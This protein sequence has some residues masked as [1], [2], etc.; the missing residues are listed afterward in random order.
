MPDHH[1]TDALRDSVLAH[2]T[3]YGPQ[4]DAAY[5]WR[6]PALP[7]GIHFETGSDSLAQA[8]VRLRRILNKAWHEG[9]VSRHDIARWYV[10]RWGG[11]KRNLPETLNDY[12]TAPEGELETR[13]TKGI[14]SWSKVLVVR[15]PDLYAI[16]DARVATSLNALQLIAGH[17]QPI[18]F[19][20]LRNQNDTIDEFQKW[21]RARRYGRP[22]YLPK[23][24]VYPTYLRVLRE[25]AGGVG[26]ASLDEIEMSLFADAENLARKAMS[27]RA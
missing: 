20:N 26:K 5:R 18:L 16:L 21:L 4:L 10:A 11:V 17:G 13:G 3:E 7:D 25:V 9:P 8:T 12:I 1:P 6:I 15:N 19:P 24:A 2:F 27:L 23:T 14:A 22:S